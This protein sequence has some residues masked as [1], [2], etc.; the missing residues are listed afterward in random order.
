LNLKFKFN[1][2][3]INSLEPLVKVGFTFEGS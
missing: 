1:G 3:L 2:F